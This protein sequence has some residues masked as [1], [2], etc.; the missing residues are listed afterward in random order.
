M[1]KTTKSFIFA[2]VFSGFCLFLFNATDVSARECSPG[3]EYSRH[4]AACIQSN[5][6]DVPDAKYSYTG[7]CLCGS[8]GS[9]HED[10]DDPN[11]A[12][13]RDR[14]YEACPGCTYACVHSSQ[15]CPHEKE[16]A[17]NENKEDG[18]YFYPLDQLDEHG[19]SPVE[20]AEF[21]RQRNGDIFITCACKPGFKRGKRGCVFDRPNIPLSDEEMARLERALLD[22][23]RN[24][25]MIF[26]TFLDINGQEPVK[27]GIVRRGD[28]ELAFTVDGESWGSDLTN[29]MNPSMWSRIRDGWRGAWGMLNPAS[30]SIWDVKMPDEEK[31]LTFDIARATMERYKK[32]IL[33]PQHY[34]FTIE[35]WYKYAKDKRDAARKLR[36]AGLLD[37][38]IDLTKGYVWKD[39]KGHLKAF[40]ANAVVKFASELQI[41]DFANAFSEYIKEREKKSAEEVAENP[42]P[43]LEFG[44]SIG[45]ASSMGDIL[46]YEKYEEAYQR[47]LLIKDMRARA[48]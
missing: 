14:D 17:E 46:L 36:D 11:K 45:T 23:D 31:Q 41:T 9:I 28:Y 16:Q 6:T 42:P 3:Y 37:G 21:I 30:W 5:C 22:L 7:A 12:C 34:M 2:I 24:D 4:F 27:I 35:S 25:Y 43:E 19:C 18:E 39:I 33:E 40:P 10:P 44:I 20:R 1:K 29:L 15:L 47:Y 48:E 8:A 38:S 32:D 13:R 26:E